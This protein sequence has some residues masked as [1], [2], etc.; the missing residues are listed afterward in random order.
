MS[1]DLV[2]VKTSPDNLE[3]G[4]QRGYTERQEVLAQETR[5]KFVLQN[6]NH[7]PFFINPRVWETSILH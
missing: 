1:S 2:I 7:F 6:C 5:Y 3:L 4:G